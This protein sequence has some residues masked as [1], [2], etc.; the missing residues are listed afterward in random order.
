MSPNKSADVSADVSA[1]M[2]ADKYSEKC[3]IIVQLGPRPKPKLWP[4][5]EH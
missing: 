3:A 4:K 1:D 5:A 2:S